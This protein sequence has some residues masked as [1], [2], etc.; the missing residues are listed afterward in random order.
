MQTAREKR[1]NVLL[2]SEQYKWSEN[3]AWY[4]DAS[5]RDGILVC[6]PDSSVGGFL[7][8]NAGFVWVEVVVVRVYSCY[9]SPNDPFEIFET[10]ILL[11]EERLSEATGGSLMGGKLNSKSPEW[12]EAHLD[13]RGILVD[14]MV[15]RNDL[16]VLNRLRRECLAARRKFTRSKGDA[17]LHEAW[18]RTKAAL[19]R[20][21]KKS[22]L[23]CWNDLIGEVEKDP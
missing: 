20:G 17:M 22:R 18:E 14:E 15:A 23:Q 12:G 3:S 9:F 11:L 13:R 6:S 8:S 7:E 5:R 2:I 21:T 10:Q 16:I 19:R 4:Q 1:A